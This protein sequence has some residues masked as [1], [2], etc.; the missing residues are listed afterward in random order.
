MPVTSDKP[1]NAATHPRIKWIA[2]GSNWPEYEDALIGDREGLLALRASIDEALTEGS[3]DMSGWDS[4]FLQLKFVEEHPDIPVPSPTW[5]DRAGAFW[6][7]LMLLIF[8]FCFIYGLYRLPDL[9]K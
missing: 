4:E 1:T 7:V 5:R 3:A 2:H 6:A 8:V 9:F